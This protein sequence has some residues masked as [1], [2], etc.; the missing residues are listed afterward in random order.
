MRIA[1]DPWRAPRGDRHSGL[2]QPRA[3]ARW[4]RSGGER[5]RPRLRES[6]QWPHEVEVQLSLFSTDA[7]VIIAKTGG[8][9]NFRILLRWSGKRD[10]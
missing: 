7:N 1:F 8:E 3:C 5:H 9:A 2:R 10:G 4:Y 6:A